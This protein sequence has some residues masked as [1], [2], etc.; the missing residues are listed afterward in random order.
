MSETNTTN[1][2]ET[3]H[4]PFIVWHGGV[5]QWVISGY[6]EA[7]R[8]F[9]P[10]GTSCALKYERKVN[11]DVN[12]ADPKDRNADD[13]ALVRLAKLAFSFHRR[14]TSGEIAVRREEVGR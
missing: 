11:P 1:P 13:A 4:Q 5:K 2:I 10:F 12:A 14:A 9:I 7:G 8:A 3:I 6:T